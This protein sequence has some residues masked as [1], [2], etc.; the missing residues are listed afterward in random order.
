MAKSSVFQRYAQIGAAARAQE[1]STELAQIERSFPGL[2]R[3]GPGKRAANHAGDEA[4]APTGKRRTRKP[5]TAAQK[6]A[7]GARMK[8]Y[9]AARRKAEA[10]K[11]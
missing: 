2:I 1:I 9:W 5:M 6:A 3:R 10:K 11:A 7:V 4:Q 8:K